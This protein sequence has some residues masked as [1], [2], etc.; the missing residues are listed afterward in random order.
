MWPKTGKPKESFRSA[1]EFDMIGNPLKLL[2][3]LWKITVD[4]GR[5]LTR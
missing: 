3:Q 2:Q 1:V 5:G 4:R